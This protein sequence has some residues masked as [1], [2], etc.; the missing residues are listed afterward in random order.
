MAVQ[1]VR[2][3]EKIIETVY[4]SGRARVDRP[5]R[6][7]PPRRQEGEARDIQTD[8]FL[9]HRIEVIAGWDRRFDHWVYTEFNHKDLVRVV[10]PIFVARDGTGR[11]VEGDWIENCQWKN[12]LLCDQRENYHNVIVMRQARIAFTRSGR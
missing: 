1:L 4:G 10:A 8:V 7:S 11:V 3:A 9:S 12:R 6:H 2:A 5:R